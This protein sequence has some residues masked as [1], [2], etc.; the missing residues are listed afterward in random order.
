MN[1]LSLS[2]KNNLTYQRGF[3]FYGNDPI[4]G[5]NLNDL[6]YFYPTQS[7]FPN[8]NMAYFTVYDKPIPDLATMSD[9]HSFFVPLTAPVTMASI[10]AAYN[11]LNKFVFFTDN[12]DGGRI[13]A[14]TDPS[15]TFITFGLFNTADAPFNVTAA[16][17][18]IA[19]PRNLVMTVN[20]DAFYYMPRQTTNF[21]VKVNGVNRTLSSSNVP[22]DNSAGFR[23]LRIILSAPVVHG[24]V[25][26]FSYTPTVI[27][28]DYKVIDQSDGYPLALFSDFNMSQL[29]HI[30]DQAVVN[31]Y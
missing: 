28:S 3:S 17:M 16:T 7:D 20:Q 8:V 14:Y 26:T 4:L 13:G 2:A 27:S 11:S 23:K 15:I 6:S 9:A 1:A 22:V 12:L 30:I 5:N 31:P 19:Q 24:D 10:V 29:P 25:V 21:T 18:Q